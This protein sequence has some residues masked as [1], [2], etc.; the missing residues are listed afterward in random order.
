VGVDKVGPVSGSR[1]AVFLDRDGVLNRA[2][3]RDGRPH[4]PQDLSQLEILPGVEE[5]LARLRAAGFLLIV[6]TNQPDVARGTQQ[7]L[8][9]EEINRALRMRLPID[10]LRVCYHD[11][12]AGC[13]C[14]K[15]EPGMLVQTARDLGIDLTAS[16]MLGDRWTDVEAGRKAGCKT[17]FIDYQYAEANRS[18]PDH[19]VK[20]LSEA[21]DWILGSGAPRKGDAQHAG[22]G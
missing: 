8:V 1:R 11:T 4:P 9:V 20:S 18:R 12:D 16:Y 21:V 17:V 3:R 5:A 22:S 6:V 15:P 14:R 7:W 10:D 2:L 13:S 19:T